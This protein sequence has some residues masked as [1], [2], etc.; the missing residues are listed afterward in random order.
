MSNI[1]IAG[2]G[3][4]KFG[5]HI[6]RTLESLT[7]EAIEKAL[8]DA[9]CDKDE[10]GTA[11]FTGCTQGHL[12]GQGMVLG[13]VYLSKNGIEG[14]PIF[15]VENAC[16]SGSSGFYLANQMLKSGACDIALVV[17]AEK[18]NVADK[19]KMF[20]VFDGAWDVSNPEQNLKTLL[21]PAE[22]FEVPPGTTSE[23]PYS[24]FMDVYAAFCRNHMKTFGTTQR[25]IAAVSAKNHQHS[26]HN[27]LSQFR[28]PYTI[29]EVM[30]APPITYPLTLPMC[31][32]ISDGAAAVVVCNEEGL[33]KLNAEKRAV[34]VL[35]AV[36]RSATSRPAD[37][38]DQHC[39]HLAAKEAYEIAGVGPQD[40]DVA[41][42]HDATAMGEILH[43]ENLGLVG[44][45]EA[46]PAAENG[47]FTI[48]GR[49]PINPS[50]GLESKG[51]PLGATGLGQIH[52]LVVQLRGEAGARQ[53][54]GAKH[55]VHE[56]SGGLVGIE[57]GAVSI[58]ILAKA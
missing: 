47:D 7:G 20:S 58:N 14:I 53:V 52:E 10:I 44:F 24:V 2:V 6:E 4:T 5:R 56:N 42:V 46:G 16:A 27:E 3:M 48:G 12:H 15:N 17:G 32:P 8:A 31:A 28:D 35:A 36:I 45:G 30:A 29:D 13:Q 39:E 57:E 33:K 37:Q 41:E 51:H 43:A 25:Q 38:W 11:F 21:K 34:R 54:V 23:R 26:V 40:M 55:A 19:A 49:I 22:G 50:G 1:Y 9:G 18:M